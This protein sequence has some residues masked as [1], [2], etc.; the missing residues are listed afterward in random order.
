MSGLPE[1]ASIADQLGGRVRE[2][3]PL[4]EVAPRASYGLARVEQAKRTMDHVS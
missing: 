1:V 3:P 4:M 2:T